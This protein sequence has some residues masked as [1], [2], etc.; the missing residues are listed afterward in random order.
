MRGSS[1]SLYAPERCRQRRAAA[2]VEFAV[3]GTVFVTVVMGIFE[4]GRAYM[5]QHQL[6]N[7]AR[8]GCRI[9]ILDNKATS[10][11]TTAVNN[12]LNAQGINASQATVSVAVNGSTSEDIS[13]SQSQDNITVTI[14]IAASAVTW[15]PVPRFLSGNLSGQYTLRRE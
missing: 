13:A 3:C 10:D 9:G 2:A 15:V 14:T 8:L 12:N 6:T 7:A 1:A 4:L 5:V 11:V